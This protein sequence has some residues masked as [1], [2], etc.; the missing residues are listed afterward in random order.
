MEAF[1]KEVRLMAQWFE[2]QGLRVIYSA[3]SGWVEFSRGIFQSFPYYRLINPSNQELVK[4]FKNYHAMALRYSTPLNHGAGKL[5]YHIVCDKESFPLHSLCKKARHDIAHGMEYAVYRPI[6]IDQLAYEGWTLR[7]ETL[8]RQGRLH[9]ENQK[10]WENLC[11]SA[12]GNPAFEAWGAIHEG[13][14]VAA[15]FTCT[16]DKVMSI[17]YQQSLTAHLKFGV[18]NTLAHIC[19]R[20]AMECSDIKRVFY[21]LESLD[22][23]S[24]VDEFKL[25]MG[26]SAQ[27]VRQRVVPNP[28]L[29]PFFNPSSHN[30]LKILLNF[31]PGNYTLAKAEG[32]FRF[33]LDGKLPLTKQDWP[34]VLHVEKETIKETGTI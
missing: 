27:P 13:K 17:L 23:P 25:R 12:E 15:L 8:A 20:N 2:S 34:V 31:Q 33:Y 21:G 28:T 3:S 16:V 11:L 22:A 14:L 6:P 30:L 19:A 7:S 4:I 10:F 1:S 29:Q 5:S 9:A 26:F 18:N 32:M 24:S